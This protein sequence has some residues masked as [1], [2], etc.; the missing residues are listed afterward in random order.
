LKAFNIIIAET[1]VSLI[2]NGAII[3]TVIC[4]TRVA[5]AAP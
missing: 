4:E 1:L 5:I 3:A 2:N